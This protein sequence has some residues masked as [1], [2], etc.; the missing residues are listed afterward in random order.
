M[1]ELCDYFIVDSGSIILSKT[2]EPLKVFYFDPVVVAGIVDFSKSISGEVP[3]AYYYTLGAEDAD[4]RTENVTKLRLWFTDV[5]LLAPVA[6]E[7]REKFPVY[8]F[9]LEA[10]MPTH[11]ALAGRNGFVEIIPIGL[12]KSNAIKH[13][14]QEASIPAKDVITIGD[15]LNDLEMVRDFDGFAIDGSELAKVYQRK[16]MSSI[17]SLVGSLL[18][19][20]EMLDTYT[21]DGKYLG[22][23]PRNECHADNP[24]FY[25]KPVWI[26]II[27]D[28]GHVLV[29]KRAR[30]KKTFSGYWDIPSAGHVDAGESSINGAVRE[31]EEELGIKTKPED[32]EYIGEY[33]SEITWEIGQIYL[34]KINLKEEEM[35]LQAEEVE[36]VKWLS[37]D[38]FEK[39][40]FSDQF[41]SYDNEFKK[42]SL[43]LLK[44][45]GKSNNE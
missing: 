8:A 24:G 20:D 35:H 40:L 10:G 41:V 29:Q 3:A 2:G 15:G 21:R 31:T 1:K 27:N 32:Y 19:T 43:E 23:R 9:I 14:L 16:I 22:V 37:I 6:A 30:A 26:W 7:I 5:S 38:E 13:L 34:L 36:R 44:S 25:H 18:E 11:Q 17:S 12:G 42:M 33:I 4:Y 45:K 39:L 28:E